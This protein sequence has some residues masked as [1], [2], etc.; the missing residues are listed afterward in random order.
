MIE[1]HWASG[2]CNSWCVLLALTVK[3]VP[4]ASKLL[5]LSKKEHKTAEYLALNPRG[6]VP[7]IRDGEFVLYESLAILTYLDR[8]YPD[9]PLYGETPAE[10]ALIARL[11]AEDRFYLEPKLDALL[12]PFYRGKA[13]EIVE[14]L[15]Q[16]AA[17]V[18]EELVRLE[19][20]LGPGEAPAALSEEYLAGP[21]L[22]AADLTIFPHLQHLRR[23]LSRPDVQAHDLG[24]PSYAERY[25]RLEAWNARIE[26][27]PGYELTYPPHWK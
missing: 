2:S 8:K 25:P 7:C 17:A 26:Q 11:V 14:E 5:Q 20:L 18:H 15:P 1:V 22:S 21:R 23:G 9:P 16:R 27:I 3:R 6:K 12:L 4:Y 19:A 10:A 24:F 13:N